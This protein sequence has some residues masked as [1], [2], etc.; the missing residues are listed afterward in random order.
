MFTALPSFAGVYEDA[1]K[2]KENVLLYL[3]TPYCRTCKLMEPYFD[4]TVKSHDNLKGVKVNAQTV[5]GSRLM[6]KFNGRHVP[7]IVMSSPKGKKSVMVEPGCL[8]DEVCVERVLK[9]LK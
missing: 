9:G 6:Y 2:G 5:Y 1:L 7:Y 4:Q 3:Y 8:V